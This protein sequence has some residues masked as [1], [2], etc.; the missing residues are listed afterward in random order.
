MEKLTQYDVILDYLKRN[1]S[2]T[3]MEAIKEFSITRLSA[4]MFTLRKDGYNIES[5]YKTGKN[6]KYGWAT[7]YVEYVLKDDK[8]V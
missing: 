7:H 4:I 5:S 2:I 8:Q 1:G 6:K 3:S